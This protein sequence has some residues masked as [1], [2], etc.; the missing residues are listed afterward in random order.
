MPL[1]TSDA[2]VSP[3]VRELSETICLKV[4]VIHYRLLVAIHRPAKEIEEKFGS[5]S[6]L[7]RTLLPIQIQFLAQTET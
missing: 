1:N 4:E 7:L 6:K 3:R 5:Y 2:A